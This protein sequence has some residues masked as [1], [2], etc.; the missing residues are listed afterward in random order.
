MSSR[1]KDPNTRGVFTQMQELIECTNPKKRSFRFS[2]SRTET[3][4]QDYL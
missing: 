1:R 4:R 3:F 2:P